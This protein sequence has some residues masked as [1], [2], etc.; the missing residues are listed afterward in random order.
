VVHYLTFPLLS[1]YIVLHDEADPE[2]GGSEPG[3]KSERASQDQTV[4]DNPVLAIRSTTH[5]NDKG[6][7]MR[8]ILRVFL[9]PLII[10][11]I[12]VTNSMSQGGYGTTFSL[13]A[14]FPTGVFAQSFETGIGGH[15]DFHLETESYLHISVLLGFT[16]WGI[17]K[18]Q[19]NDRY[20][21]QGGVGNL[22]LEGR[23]NA[24]PLLIGVKLLSPQGNGGRF[25]GLLEAGVY[26]Y[27]GKV[28]GTKVEGGVVTQNIFEET[29]K[30]TP[31]V[32]LG[33]G[34]QFP[35][36]SSTSLDL[37]ARY[38]FLKRD[39]YYTYDFAGNATG[40]DTDRFFSLALGITYTFSAT[41]GP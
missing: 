23:L 21:A 29:S 36:G 30:T 4:R 33:V 2:Q 6:T 17:D 13:S 16:H 19:I 37:C 15:V 26:I 11:I 3:L 27:D 20:R 18:E 31:G 41:S 7:L 32:N 35:F 40:V 12:G 22:Q 39:T 8:A 28:T 10:S 24:F 34:F 1:E 9:L 25:Y 14:A 5:A 38:H